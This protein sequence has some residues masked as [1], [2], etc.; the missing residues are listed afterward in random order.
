MYQ[1]LSKNQALRLN[2]L[3]DYY[4]ALHTPITKASP[5]CGIGKIPRGKRRGTPNEC[6][7]SKQIRYW[8]IARAPSDL[9]IQHEDIGVILQRES[10]KL[11]NLLSRAKKLVSEIKRINIQLENKKLSKGKTKTIESAKAKSLK[12]R[13]R[14]IKEIKKQKQVVS[15]L[16][17]L[18][19]E[20][21]M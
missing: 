19:K 9:F 15:N 8:G 21:N 10:L 17:D 12:I 5:Y 6:F 14:L 1:G 11:N 16:A 4:E 7:N 20:E 3:L 18:E 2:A 13:D